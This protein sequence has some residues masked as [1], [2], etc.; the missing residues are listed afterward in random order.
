[1]NPQTLYNQSL[2][3][4]NGDGVEENPEESF[5][6]NLEAAECGHHDAV[7]AVGWY[8]LNGVGVPED[9][10]EARAWYKKSARQGDPRAM[11][12]LGNIAYL[13][14]DNSDALRWFK[15]AVDHK[16]Y[17]SIFWIGK[18]YWHGRGVGEDKKQAML[19]FNEAASHKVKE[20]QRTLKWLNRK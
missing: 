19:L 10:E 16:H 8:Y 15:Q 17:R 7:L 5:K 18:L 11:F 4:L 6:L 14:R 20:A 2:D 12:S 1:M 3:L 13:E 9:V